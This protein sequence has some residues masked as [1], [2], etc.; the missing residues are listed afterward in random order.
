MFRFQRLFFGELRSQFDI[1]HNI[2]FFEDKKTN[3][4]VH[5][6]AN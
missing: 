1:F 6:S 5:K 3:N 4:N 2:Y